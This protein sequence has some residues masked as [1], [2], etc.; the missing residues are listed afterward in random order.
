MS[1]RQEHRYCPKHRFRDPKEC[2]RALQKARNKRSW[3]EVEGLDI[4]RREIRWY[5]HPF[6]GGY[7]LTSEP[8]SSNDY[9][10]AA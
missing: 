2:K 8:L 5:Y 9:D 4:K 6:C 10:V 1:K 7:H 3:A